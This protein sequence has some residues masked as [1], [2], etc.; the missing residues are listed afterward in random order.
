MRP[1]RKTSRRRTKLT[2]RK[3]FQRI[4]TIL[5]R[6]KLDTKRAIELCRENGRKVLCED[7]HE[8]WALVKYTENVQEGIKQL[9]DINRAI[10]PKLVEFPSESSSR[11]ETSWKDLI[12]MRDRLAHAFH[13]IDHEILWCTATQDLP[14]LD[15]LLGVLQVVIVEHNAVSF[16]FK[17]G[18][19]RRLPTLTDGEV[20]QGGNSIPIIEILE[21]GRV[22]CT[23][24][25]RIDDRTVRFQ[26]SRK[27][28]RL[29]RIELRDP[30]GTSPPERLWSMSQST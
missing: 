29:Q 14:R 9:D 1:K 7:H 18:L 4:E 28:L 2:A 26:S 8:F 11:A 12:G 13:K 5:Q 19:L 3:Q 16:A 30:E 20:L 24:I 15:A 17:A 27:G 10:F 6:M 25:G 22:E 23:R 21:D